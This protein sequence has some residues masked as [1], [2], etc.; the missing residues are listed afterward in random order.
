MDKVAIKYQV[1]LENPEN[2]LFSVTCTIQTPDLLGQEVALAKWIPGSY[3]IRDFSKHLINLQARSENGQALN[4]WPVSTAS[5][6]IEPC[7][8]AIIID[9]QVYAWDLSVRGAHLDQT[10]GFFNGTS[11]FLAVE[12][13]REA[14]CEVELLASEWTRQNSW[15]IATTLPSRSVD[16]NGFGRYQANHFWDLIDYPVEMGTY[17][18]LAFEA[19]GIPHRMT[20]TGQVAIEQVDQKR[21]IED[22]TR[23]CETELS[24][25]SEPYPIDQ[26][27]FQ[28]TVTESDYGGLEHLNSTALICS[29]NDLPYLNDEK[30]TAGYLQFLELCA[31]EYFHLWNVKRIQPKAF[32]YPSLLEPVHTNQLWWFEGIT[33]Y[34][35]GQLLYRA[36]ILDRDD[37]L[38][39]L[40]IEMTRVYRMPGRFKQSVAESS[41]LTWTKFYQQDENAPN[42]IVSYYTKGS[43]IALALDL[44]IQAETNGQKSLDTILRYLW[45]QYGQTATGLEEGEIE[46]ICSQVSGVDLTR[47]FEEA[48]YGTEDIDFERLFAPFD[49]QFALRP[50]AN[51]KDLGGKTT[52]QQSPCNL[53]ANLLQTEHQTL[54][55]THVWQ[56]QTAALAGLAAGDEIIAINDLKIKTLDALETLLAR[57]QPGDQLRCHFFRRDELM[58]TQ[59]ILTPPV[60]DR[61][62]LTASPTLKTESL[63]WPIK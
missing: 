3:L 37:Y 60:S 34:Y 51:I 13:Q 10:H 30:R 62:I 36:G 6:R 11:L 24:L 9:Y 43:L 39:Q 41:Y 23:I 2:H 7:A 19:A 33:S 20:I 22:L 14:H 18:T 52:S 12:G 38:N 27:L 48:L 47:F 46:R 58:Q 63:L 57:Y 29:R 61:V 40:A 42:A 4:I 49:I 56:S 8:S 15:K 32:Q 50:A 31:H 55:L 35:D 25:F 44:R 28:V 1:S 5:W 17:Q 54:T 16:A 45:Q 26:Y 21:L 59:L 53:G